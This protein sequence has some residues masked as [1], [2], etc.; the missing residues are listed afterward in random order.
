VAIRARGEQTD[1]AV[2]RPALGWRAGAY[3][4]VHGASGLG[5]RRGQ[6]GADRRA[7][8]L[9]RPARAAAVGA[10]DAG[11]AGRGTSAHPDFTPP[12]NPRELGRSERAVSLA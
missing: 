1:L 11:T 8:Q 12:G 6:D 5:D 4:A 7:G 9:R 3:R 10:V 2:L